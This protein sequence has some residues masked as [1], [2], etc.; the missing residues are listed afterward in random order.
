MAITIREQ[1]QFMSNGSGVQAAWTLGAGTTIG[2]LAVVIHGDDYYTA[3]A[4]TSPGGTAVSSWGTA[5]YTFDGGSNLG[6]VKVWAAPVTTGGTSTVTTTSTNSDNERV[7]AVFILYDTG[8]TVTFDAALGQAVASGLSADAPSVTPATAADLLLCLWM[9]GGGGGTSTTYTVPGTMTPYAGLDQAGQGSARFAYQLLAS[10]AATGVRTATLTPAQVNT[11]VSVLLQT[12]SSAGIP[13]GL[14]H[15]A[16]A[17]LGA[18]T[19]P[20]ILNAGPAYASSA[21]DLGGGSGSWAGTA[22]ATG[23]P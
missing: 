17:A 2:D 3:A 10:G 1:Q 22:Y 5:K 20:R 21:T 23:G 16:G 12:S 19:I 8:N 7:A 6:H 14:A 15:G 9:I 13:A 11:T 4:L 18:W